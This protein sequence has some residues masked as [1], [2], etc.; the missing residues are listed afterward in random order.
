MDPRV[1]QI[2]SLSESWTSATT[3][4]HCP[5]CRAATPDVVA[6]R[7]RVAALFVFLRQARLELD[8]LAELLGVDFPE[9]A[10]STSLRSRSTTT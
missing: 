6:S 1:S 4:E 10:S 7:V 8:E 3:V 5:A 2:P 9:D